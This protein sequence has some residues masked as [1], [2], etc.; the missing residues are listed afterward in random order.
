MLIVQLKLSHRINRVDGIL[1]H[2]EVVHLLRYDI[3]LPISLRLNLD[4][5]SSVLFLNI[6]II[7]DI[8]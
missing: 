4:L 6:L 1:L 8:V 7:H 2:C 5:L 3:A